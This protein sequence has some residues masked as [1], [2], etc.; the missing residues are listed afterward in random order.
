MIRQ[1]KTH[2]LF[3]LSNIIFFSLLLVF[4]PK[5]YDYI[6]REDHL[7]ENLTALLFIMTSA[8]LFLATKNTSQN[9]AKKALLF[10][11]ALAFC[12]AAGEEISWGQRIFNIETPEKLK[13]I[14]DQGELNLH[15]IDKKF[16]DRMVDI[17]TLAMTIGA[18]LLLLFNVSKI[19]RIPLLSPILILVFALTLFY[20]QYNTSFFDI[21]LIAILP[22]LLLLYYAIKERSYF[23]IAAV[24]SGPLLGVA[25]Y[26]LHSAFQENFAPHNNSANEYRE[27]LFA[28]CCAAYAF[29]IKRFPEIEKS[30]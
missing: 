14:N 3:F 2:Y 11:T 7:I 15:N 6:S 9:K 21:H 17:S 23:L 28:L 13:E 26:Y 25:L 29:Q 8:F 16:F 5:T 1:N 27:Y 18:A 22:L 19:L 4:L 20:R 12:W 10:F 24:L 30:L